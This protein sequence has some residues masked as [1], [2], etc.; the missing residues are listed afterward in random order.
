MSIELPVW[1]GGLEPSMVGAPSVFGA[2]ELLLTTIADGKLPQ[3]RSLRVRVEGELASAGAKAA[4]V[5]VLEHGEAGVVQGV[6]TS[7]DYDLAGLPFPPRL[8]F[9]SK[10]NFRKFQTREL[11]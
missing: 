11:T 4:V 2:Y 6:A 9:Y 3:L 10:R 1:F 5:R 8:L 7:D